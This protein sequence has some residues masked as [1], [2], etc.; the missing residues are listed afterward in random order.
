MNIILKHK[1]AFSIL[2]CIIL[3]AP[4]YFTTISNPTEL[5]FGA[6]I[7]F[8]VALFTT[9]STSQRIEDHINDQFDRDFDYKT[10][11][12]KRADRKAIVESLGLV[13]K[14]GK[15]LYNKIFKKIL[16]QRKFNVDEYLDT[17]FPKQK[18][19]LDA[20]ITPHP[21]K[22][23]APLDTIE[24]QTEK[25]TTEAKTTKKVKRQIY[26][27]NGKSIGE[28]EV[29]VFT[30]QA[31]AKVYHDW[32]H[33]DEEGVAASLNTFYIMIRVAYPELE[34]LTLEEK[35]SLGKMWLPGFRRYLSENWAYLGIP[36]LATMGT[37]LPKVV[38][39]RRKKKALADSSETKKEKLEK[40]SDKFTSRSGRVWND[41]TQVWEKK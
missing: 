37:F 1:P 13:P 15:D 19:R 41:K 35:A 12:N 17:R 8:T 20:T 21:Q 34:S 31:G 6:S 2:C 16:Y 14:R 25:E 30:S 10:K 39:A 26:D 33:F 23:A 32:Q 9:K 3:S 5:V 24:G 7:I 18:T 28:A 11:S 22:L 29:E 4:F 40:K 36:F 27:K 38:A